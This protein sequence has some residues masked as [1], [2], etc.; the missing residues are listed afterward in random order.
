MVKDVES[1]AAG[2]DKGAGKHDQ[3]NSPLNLIVPIIYKP[4]HEN[5][6]GKAKV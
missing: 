1:P 4:R 5:Y 2:Q 6:C 3:V